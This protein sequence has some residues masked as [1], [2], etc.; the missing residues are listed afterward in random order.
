MLVTCPTW[1]TY[2]P[3]VQSSVWGYRQRLH[4]SPPLRSRLLTGE[5]RGSRQNKAVAR[6]ADLLAVAVVS[7]AAGLTGGA[8]SDS[9]R[10]TSGFRFAI[11]IS[12]ALTA[13]SGILAWLTIRDK[14]APGISASDWRNFAR[15][16]F[17]ALNGPPIE[18]PARQRTLN[19]SGIAHVNPL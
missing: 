2:S 8:F 15:R 17:C 7:V 3:A 11:Q 10:F 1:S 9:G 13:A 16:T 14:I 19:Y 18:P 4:L 5:A 6:T 12:A